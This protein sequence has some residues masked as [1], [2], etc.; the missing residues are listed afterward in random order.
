MDNDM[1]K[2]KYCH[3]CGAKIFADAIMCPNC[4][5]MQD[6]HDVE[7]SQGSDRASRKTRQRKRTGFIAAAVFV[8]FLACAAIG[9]IITAVQSISAMKKPE[10]GAISTDVI[11]SSAVWYPESDITFTAFPGDVNPGD[12]VRLEV[13]AKANTDYSIFVDIGNSELQSTE[14]I[15][16]TS[17]GSGTVSWSWHIP[18]DATPGIY[19]I[20]VSDRT[21]G[22]NRIDYSI[23]DGNGDIVG[24]P[25]K[26]DAAE[27]ESPSNAPVMPET[28][29][30]TPEV[31]EAPETPEVPESPEA[32]ENPEA[33][34]A[35]ETPENPEAP[36][37]PETNQS[38]E[39][40]TST[41]P[42][43]ETQ[44]E[45]VYITDSGTKY[46][47]S[48]CRYLSDSSNAISKSAA[49][50]SGYEPCSVCNP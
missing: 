36:E 3:K 24:E 40:V 26:R 29:V 48:G 17:N 19:Y 50:A 34:E 13:D 6:Q 7:H 14:L 32:P 42:T 23:L 15:S 41:Q 38:S 27:D 39:N 43:T 30:E 2:Y 8:A 49:I 33:P 46:H 35:P 18:D 44:S 11:P 20:Q 4:K 12:Y 5:T 45:T 22:E 9:W 31:P 47:R 1:K 21:G 37:N 16:A 10:P 28:S 25:P